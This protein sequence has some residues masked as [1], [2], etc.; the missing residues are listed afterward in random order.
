M[1]KVPV[2]ARVVLEIVGAPKEH[3]EKSLKEYV[4]DI[5]KSNEILT[6]VFHPAE[7]KERLWTSFFELEIKFKSAMHLLDFCFESMPSSVEI[8][9]PNEI[10]FKTNDLTDFLNDLQSRIHYADM[11]VKSLKAEKTLLDQNA[12]M[13][14]Q[15]FIM[16]L[17]EQEPKTAEKLAEGVGVKKEEL[18]PF[19]ER[20]EKSGKVKK[21]NDIY[22]LDAKKEA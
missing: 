5:K 12:V 7:E 20:L 4:A 3:V 16:R 22:S 10:G 11:Q 1:E 18:L 21:Q 2:T 14:F 6:E 9:E 15:N 17:L 19:I 8:M 13:I